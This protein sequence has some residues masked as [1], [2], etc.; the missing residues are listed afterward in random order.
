MRIALVHPKFGLPGG[1]ER[2]ATGLSRELAGRNHD[3]H[4]FGRRFAGDF[5]GMVLHRVPALPFGRGIKT[6]S[7]WKLTERMVA[8][9]Q[10]DVI[11]GFGK[12]TCQTV[13]RTGG[14]THASYMERQGKQAPSFY[15]RVVLNIENR[16]FSSPR[17]RLTI[18]PSRWIAR[19]VRKQHPRMSARLEI[20]PNGV[21]SGHF[22]PEGRPRDREA[23]VNR[24]ALDGRALI[25]LL[26][27]TNFQLKGLDTAIQTLAHIDGAQLM[28]AGGDDPSPYVS[29][30]HRCGVA[31]RVHFL[32]L[33][34][35]MARLYRAADVLIHPTRYD[36]FANVCLEACA[37]GT[38]V[39][40]THHNGFSDLLHDQRGGVIFA[41][42]ADYAGM[43]RLLTGL[44]QKG[45]KGRESA[46]ALALENDIGMHVNA[47]ERLYRQHALLP[48]TPKDIHA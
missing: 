3:M 38:P 17:L 16:L 21:D 37:C 9:G 2:Y 18:C 43:A 6:W 4:L 25:F 32:G 42:D 44:A 12:T 7:F 46:R 19:E 27:A 10:F 28:V 39:A 47:V 20:V 11:Q 30:A 36:P 15:D 35:D 24:L 31:E 22:I 33:Q 1:A 34:T 29:L 40:T 41:Q 8:A 14:G 23:L 26:V 45:H 5:H 13:H 48:A